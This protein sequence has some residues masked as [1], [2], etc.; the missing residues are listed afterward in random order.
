MKGMYSKPTNR[1]E[2]S[3]P[4]NKKLY[5][6][7]VYR[8]ISKPKL[9]PERELECPEQLGLDQESSITFEIYS[10][11]ACLKVS[12]ETLTTIDSFLEQS[13]SIQSIYSM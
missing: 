8:S 7:S 3:I 4:M 11:Y 9:V 10:D 12:R 13:R 1:T 2:L 6:A 5:V